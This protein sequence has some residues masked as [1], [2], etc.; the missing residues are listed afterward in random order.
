MTS[1]SKGLHLYA[2]LDG[3][4]T[5]EEVRDYAKGIAEELQ[6]EHPKLMLSQMTKARRSGKVF[7]DW[8]QNTGAKTTISP[9]SMRGGSSPWSRRRGPGRRS[10]QGPTT[11]WPSS[12]CASRRSSSGSR[13]RATCSRSAPE[14]DRMGVASTRSGSG[15][16]RAR[17]APR[18]PPAHSGLADQQARDRGRRKAAQRAPAR[19]T[20]E[21]RTPLAARDERPGRRCPHELVTR[22]DAIGLQFEV[23]S[24]MEQRLAA[25]TSSSRAD[26]L[27]PSVGRLAG[28]CSWSFNSTGGAQGA[29]TPEDAR[30]GRGRD[31]AGIER[32]PLPDTADRWCSSSEGHHVQVARR[33]WSNV[34]CTCS[35]SAAPP[36]L[37]EGRTQHPEA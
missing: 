20:S 6:A 36:H 26:A 12:T 9:Y 30:R 5:Y 28:R 8:S 10:R 22:T 31:P 2:G 17:V 24:L 23:T 14:A 13:T 11:R 25:P 37:V 33:R 7:L 32:P 21:T 29:R 18:R 15:H 19:R 35:V 34:R 3:K 16:A 4:R 27:G 1:G